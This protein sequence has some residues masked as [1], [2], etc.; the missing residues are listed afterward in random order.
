MNSTFARNLSKLQ[1]ISSAIARHAV[2]YRPSPILMEALQLDH[3]LIHRIEEKIPV[4]VARETSI[5]NDMLVSVAHPKL[6]RLEIA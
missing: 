2:D 3:R 1:N 6:T 5:D 4:R